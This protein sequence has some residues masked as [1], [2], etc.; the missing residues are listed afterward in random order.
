MSD[1]QRIFV[2]GN[3]FDLSLGLKTSYFD[4]IKSATFQSKICV[5]TVFKYLDDRF[6]NQNWIDVES[7]LV[8]LSKESGDNPEFFNEYKQLRNCL[9][10]YIQ[11]IDTKNINESSPAYKTLSKHFH[12]DNSYIVNFNYTN[13]AH[14]ILSGLGFS[15]SCA[16]DYI[17]HIHGSSHDNDIIFG[18]N[19]DARIHDDHVFLYKS[20]LNNNGGRILKNALKNAGRSS[21]LAIL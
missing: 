1:H 9:H 6:N 7:E 3:G 14:I 16:H 20:T 17:H 15:E 18:V 10:E 13:T 5:N 12:P 19:D 21:F 2:I 8:K 4:F 11:S